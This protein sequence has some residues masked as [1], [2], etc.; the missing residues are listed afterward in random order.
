MVIVRLNIFRGRIYRFYLT[1]QRLYDVSKEIRL[2]IAAILLYVWSIIKLPLCYFA[3]DAC[4]P[5]F[6]LL[7][8]LKL[9]ILQLCWII[10]EKL[11]ESFPRIP[12][13]GINFFCI[14]NIIYEC[15][16]RD[17]L[18]YTALRTCTSAFIVSLS[19]ICAQISS[20]YPWST[21][22]ALCTKN[23]CSTTDVN[24]N[25]IM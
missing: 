9:L 11:Y 16:V 21:R 17:L 22:H 23:A 19:F 3:R 6:S 13:V 4:F 20:E 5:F 7:L 18:W 2:R 10:S 15:S 25:A 24:M 8:F 1:G 14:Y 12:Y